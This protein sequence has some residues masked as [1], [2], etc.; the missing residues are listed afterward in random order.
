VELFTLLNQTLHGGIFHP[1]KLETRLFNQL[2][3]SV[4]ISDKKN[5]AT[6]LKLDQPAPNYA[7]TK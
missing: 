1:L 2:S 3:A 7:M 5:C 4:S 6:S